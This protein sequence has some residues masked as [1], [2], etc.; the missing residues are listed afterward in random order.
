MKFFQKLFPASY[1]WDVG[2]K[3][4]ESSELEELRNCEWTEYKTNFSK[5][6]KK[7]WPT[8]NGTYHLHRQ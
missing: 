2:A 3:M 5:N 7:K 6:W 1:F 8:V 4:A